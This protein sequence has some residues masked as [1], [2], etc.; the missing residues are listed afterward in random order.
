MND[1]DVERKNKE[2]KEEFDRKV[3]N[4]EIQI[5]TDEYLQKQ[6]EKQ[7]ELKRQKIA[8]PDTMGKTPATILLIIGMCGSLIFKQWYYVWAILL[9]WYFSQDRV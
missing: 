8:H 1:P 5:Y 2:Y 6:M 9:W 7:E 4:G 3:R